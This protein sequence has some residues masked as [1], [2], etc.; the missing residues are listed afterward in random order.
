MKNKLLQW[1]L[2]AILFCGAM[3]FT[4]CTNEDNPADP[5]ANLSEKIIGKW[6]TADIDGQTVL[7]NSKKAIT[8]VSATKAYISAA[9]NANPEIGAHWL[10]KMEVAVAIDGNK[11]TVTSHPD[12]H[13]TT[14]EEL[15]VTTIS[16]SEFSANRKL[17]ATVDG[18]IVDTKNEII[19]YVKQTADY[20]EAILGLWECQGITGGE[21]NNDD[22]A[23]LEFLADGTYNFY[24]RSD[25]GVW[26]LVPRER[27]EYFVDGN[28]LC[29]RWQA[30]GEEMS[31]EW[32]EIT[33]AADGRMQWTALRQQADGTTFQQGVTWT[34]AEARTVLASMDFKG[35]PFYGDLT[36]SYA[37]DDDC[38]LVKMKK[39]QVGTGLV[40]TEF[41]YT[42][43]PG[44]I[45]KQG[46]EEAYTVTEECSL[47]DHGRIV[48]LVRNS[49]NSE[50]Q[51][52]HHYKYTYTYDEDGR[53]ATVSQWVEG[54]TNALLTT[55]AW[56]DGELRSKTTDQASVLMVND[57][58]PGDAPAQALFGHIG[59]SEAD[60]LCPQ[61]CF[62][63]LPLHLPSK[64]TVILTYNGVEMSKRT[65]EYSYTV[66]DG[67]LAAANDNYFLHWEMR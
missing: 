15:T 58:E 9:F 5:A 19:R 16:G 23:R 39:E 17:T 3:V 22:N 20:S 21:T 56:Q 40:I 12:E 52:E 59:Y 29:T 50:T 41:D 24:R 32:W 62:G 25:A 63:T 11:V 18:N 55:F 4:S 64:Q 35:H 10:N 43:T 47:D 14:V 46:R 8:F 36:Y 37:Y 27:N 31:Y 49:I 26:S 44:H 38:R 7:T 42:Y 57:Y 45:T 61:G 33:S 6:V 2:A 67:R 1:M 53:L 54:E 66:T 65:T 60:E 51:K 28:L 30:E 13:T 48:E 34:A